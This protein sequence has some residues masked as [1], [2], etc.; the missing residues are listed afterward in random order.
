MEFIFVPTW[1]ITFYQVFAV[2]LAM[3]GALGWALYRLEKRK[4]FPSS[5]ITPKI[6]HKEYQTNII[7]NPKNKQGDSD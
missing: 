3:A 7:S 1:E 6:D 5:N 4:S 2:I